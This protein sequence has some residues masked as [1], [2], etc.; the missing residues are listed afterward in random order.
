LRKKKRAD[1]SGATDFD[2]MT[3]SCTSIYPCFYSNCGFFLWKRTCK[4]FI[5]K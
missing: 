4:W 3:F 1:Q 2:L 5:S